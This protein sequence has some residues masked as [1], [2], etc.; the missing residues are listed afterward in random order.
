MPAMLL[1]WRS[2]PLIWARPALSRIE[3]STSMVKSSASGSGP[4]RA[5]PS[6]SA[7]SRTTYSA[8][9]LR[10]PASVMSRPAPLSSTI[11]AAS[12]DLL[13]GSG[14]QRRHLVLP[15]HPARA[16]EVQ[17]QVGAGDVDVEELAVPGDAV[18]HAAGQRGDGRVVGLQ[19]AERG[20]VDAYDGAA[21]ESTGQVV[22]E[23][24]DLGQLGHARHVTA[25]THT[26]DPRLTPH[27]RSPDPI[28]P[29]PGTTGVARRPAPCHVVRRRPGAGART[30]QPGVRRPR[31]AEHA[32]RLRPDHRPG[33]PAAEPGLPRVARGRRHRRPDLAAAG[34]GRLADP[35]RGDARPGGPRLERRQPAARRLE[36]HPRAERA[37]LVHQPLRR[38]AQRHRLPPQARRPRPLHRR[39]AARPVPG[40]GDHRG[41]GAGQRGDVPLARPGPRRARLRRTHLRRA[42]PGRWRDAAPRARPRQRQQRAAVLQ[43]VRDAA[44]RRGVRL[45]RRR[46][47]SSCPTSWSA[48][49]TRCRSSPRPRR[50]TTPTRAPRARR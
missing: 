17:H 33:R 8:R 3:R 27:A 13:F 14:G 15:A 16:G 10:V 19:A 2:T 1:W 22:D 31:P 44:G 47:P 20:D 34:A 50:S 18:D 35:D 25:V 4:S 9:L 45:P 40:R 41:L 6:T 46:R 24:F 36:R 39:G 7:G 49:R 5:M 37:D 32:G 12:G 21:F 48:P 26:P 29:R 23:R 28:D 38:A 30:G 43:P 42:G 11:R